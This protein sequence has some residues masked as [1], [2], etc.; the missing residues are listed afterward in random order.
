[1]YDQV[2][3]LLRFV[4]AL[5][6]TLT[7]RTV[8]AQSMPPSGS[9]G[10][11]INASY[12]D[13]SNNNGFVV[14]AVANF[15]GAGSVSGSY[16]VEL[17][18]SP[19]QTSQPITG[20]FTGTYSSNPDGTGTLTTTADNGTIFKFATVITDGGQGLQLVGTSCSTCDIGGTT[21]ISGFARAAY[22]GS[23]NAGSYG[24]QLTNSPLPAASVGVASFDGAGNAAM[25]STFV[26]LSGTG[27]QPNI[28]TGS[29]NGTYSSNPDGSGAFTLTAANGNMQ[30]Y[31]FV[32]TDSGSGILL[33]QT[34]RA[35]N[36][37]SFG[38]GR[39]Q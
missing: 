21:I 33:L 16:T 9:F 12:S 8:S 23:L 32:I 7:L 28:F 24:L 39:R 34:N 30:T 1:M 26:G 29:N 17:G 10:L 36:G 37:V 35:G 27:G 5:V 11:L 31:V 4:S 6:L 19:T 15:D 13:L 22:T 25:S 14:L 20:T 3:S 18:S 38:T 2:R